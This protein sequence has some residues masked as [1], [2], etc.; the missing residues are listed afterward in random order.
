[1]SRQRQAAGTQLELF[2]EPEH[3]AAHWSNKPPE[4]EGQVHEVR[5]VRWVGVG[6]TWMLEET[7]KRLAEARARIAENE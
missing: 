3:Q 1:V 5:G 2:A 7:V 6:A 4:H